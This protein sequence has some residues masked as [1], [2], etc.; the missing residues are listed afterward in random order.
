MVTKE[1]WK[2]RWKGLFLHGIHQRP[3]H[4]IRLR[5][6][7]FFGPCGLR[8]DF[9]RLPYQQKLVLCYGSDYLPYLPTYHSDGLF[10]RRWF[11]VKCQNARFLP[12]VAKD[13]RKAK[14]PS[15]WTVI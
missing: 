12:K 1:A 6:P 8:D 4:D 13:D 10:E 14:I 15:V 2:D 5:H 11:C 3:S 7:T 9:L